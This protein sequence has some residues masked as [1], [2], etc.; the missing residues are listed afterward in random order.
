MAKELLIMQDEEVTHVAKVKGKGDFI[1]LRY[2]KSDI[3]SGCSKGKKVGELVDTGSGIQI[4]MEEIDEALDLDYDVFQNLFTL[5]KVKYE[6]D[7]NL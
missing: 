5:M 1:K 4:K 2:S 6:T 7:P 3:W